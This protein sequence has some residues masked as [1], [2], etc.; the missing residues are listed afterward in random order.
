MIDQAVI[1]TPVSAKTFT[2]RF[3]KKT[4]LDQALTIVGACSSRAKA[5]ALIEAGSVMVDECVI[6]KPAHACSGEITIRIGEDPCP[7]V[8]RGG[9]KLAAALDHF[10]ID[11]AGRVC[12]D[13]G[14][15]TGGFCDVLL[16][17]NAARVYAVD[18]GHGQM[19][20]DLV[21]EPRLVNL[22]KTHAGR[23]TANDIPDPIDLLVC[24]VSF[25]SLRKVLA[26]P[27]ALVRPGGVIIALIKPQFELGPEAIGKGGM[28]KTEPQEI[29]RLKT[30][31]AAWFETQHCASHAIIDSPIRGGDGN[32]E[33]LI[34]VRKSED[35][36]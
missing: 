7:Y 23:L 16:R 15:S 28:V 9:L 18:V 13:I 8:S 34:C 17:R 2:H 22:E 12:L 19:H 14:A 1:L 11:P 26:A 30:D 33:Y 6:Q 29:S 20:R 10:N 36:T 5:R 27:L 25:I 24:D 31:I 4:R 21:G 32:Q 35:G 3:S